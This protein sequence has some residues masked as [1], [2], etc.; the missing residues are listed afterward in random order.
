MHRASPT[1]QAAIPYPEPG[2]S[3][4]GPPKHLQFIGITV[5]GAKI[6]T[7]LQRLPNPAQQGRSHHRSTR[8]EANPPHRRRFL[9]TINQDLLWRPSL[10]CIEALRPVHCSLSAAVQCAR[11]KPDPVRRMG[12][13]QTA[14]EIVGLTHSKFRDLIPRRCVEDDGTPCARCLSIRMYKEFA[15]G[16]SLDA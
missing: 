1:K 4:P 3:H 9:G 6:T 14:R 10:R 12:F 16:S 2:A 7:H 5:Y 8:V 13:D 15:D 11:D